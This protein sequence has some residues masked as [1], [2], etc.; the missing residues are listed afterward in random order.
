MN[1]NRLI[2]QID[3]R[4]ISISVQ[5]EFLLMGSDALK[6]LLKAVKEKLLTTMQM[7]NSLHIMFVLIREKCY[8]EQAVL[9]ELTRNI[10]MTDERIAVRSESSVISVYLAR[11]SDNFPIS[12]MVYDKAEFIDNVNKVLDIGVYDN[13][14]PVLEKYLSKQFIKNFPN[15]PNN[16]QY[17]PFPYADELKLAA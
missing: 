3:Q 13:A 2:K 1:I 17:M 10:M 12:D 5:R 8:G 7:V 14:R 16:Q 6:Y 11:L 15:I 9:F 4:I